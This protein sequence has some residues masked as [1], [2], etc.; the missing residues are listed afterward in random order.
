MNTENEINLNDFAT[1]VNVIDVCTQRG[2]FK[3][4]E[5]LVIGSLR[6][7]FS[8]IVEQAKAAAEPQEEPVQEETPAE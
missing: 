2:A 6:Q 8:N 4:D 5:L 3:G 7:K 1:V